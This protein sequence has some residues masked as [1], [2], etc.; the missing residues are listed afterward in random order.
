[1]KQ[2]ATIELFSYW[3]ALRAGFDRALLDA[4]AEQ[5]RSLLAS[6]FLVEVD[7]RRAYP[8][9]VVG[10]TIAKL[11]ASARLGAS[12]LE[13]WEPGSRDLLEAMLRTVHDERVPVVLGARTR[14]EDGAPLAVEILLLP[15]A[16]GR[17]GKPRILGGMATTAPVNR[18]AP[19]G[20]LE[21]VSARAI[22]APYPPPALSRPS[23]ATAKPPQAP[24][25]PPKAHLRV[26]EGGR[27]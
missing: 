5:V 22:R 19:P 1:M 14:R 13:C 15:L 9:R 26:I 2:A 24:N 8:L 3:D 27:L 16:S 21:L 11:I 17:K 4:D 10:A 18:R 23:M 12:F 6:T 20:G 7:A 25:H